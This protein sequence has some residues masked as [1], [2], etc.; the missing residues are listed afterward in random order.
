MNKQRRKEIKDQI[1]LIEQVKSNI[2]S[3]LSDEEYYFDNMPEN[4]QGS[5]R[6]ETSQEAI[7]LLTE[8]TDALQDIIDT[9][10]ELA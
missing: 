7:D 6:G 2:E 4:L 1:K 9:L 8:S 3:I 10:S 5:M